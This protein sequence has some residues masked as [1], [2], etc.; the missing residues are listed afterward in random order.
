MNN[1]TGS[2]DCITF[3]MVRLEN[4]GLSFAIPS[5]WDIWEPPDG[6]VFL[7][8]E[9]HDVNPFEAQVSISKER[10][11][12][13]T[14]ARDYL[15]SCLAALKHGLNGFVEEESGIFVANETEVA[16]LQ[17]SS[18]IEKDNVTQRDF[19][20]V[21]EGAGYIINCKAPSRDFAKWHRVFT[22]V[23]ESVTQT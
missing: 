5:T 16:W 22:T 17:Y 12:P 10:L 11:E 1:S 8:S 2:D 18:V 7:A 20:V 21:V 4:E 6:L 14:H 13:E 19:Y 15:V 23:G 3:S 9:A